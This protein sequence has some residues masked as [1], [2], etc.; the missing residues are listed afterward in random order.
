MPESTL[1]LSVTDLKAEIGH[2]LGYGRGTA[3]GEAAWTNQQNNNLTALLKSGLSQVYT[4]PPLE[5]GGASYSWSF[6]RPFTAFTLASGVSETPLPDDFGGF[7][8]SLYVLS[9]ASATRQVPLRVYNPGMVVQM[10]AAYPDA[11]GFPKMACELSAPGTDATRSTRSVLKVWPK[12][13]AEYTVMAEWKHLQDALTGLYPYPPGGAEHAELFKA[14]VLAAA[15]LQLDDQPGARMAFF[16]QRL[17]ASISVD[18]KRKGN[19]LGY[20]ADRSDHRLV[21]RMPGANRYWDN[22]AVTFNGN[23]L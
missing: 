9:P 20:N 18:R 12:T 23:P 19:D 6:L 16:M 17:A 1:S 22:P 2:Y 4:P 10:H 8:G 21:P 5:P 14:S 15:E 3:F 11:V 7:E 13:D